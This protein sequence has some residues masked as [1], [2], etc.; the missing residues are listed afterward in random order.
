M[1]ILK[2]VAI[3]IVL[4]A[5]VV[6]FALVICTIQFMVCKECLFKD[7]CNQHWKEKDFVPPCQNGLRQMPFH[8]K[9]YTTL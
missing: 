8:D 6:F 4:V 5:F 7:Q 1:V 3:V 2:F 9:D